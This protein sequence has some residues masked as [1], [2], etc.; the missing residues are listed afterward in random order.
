MSDHTNPCRDDGISLVEILVGVA[1][2]GLLMSSLSFAI[3]T[4]VRQN[5]NTTGRLNNARSEES[6]GVWMPAD[7]ASAQTVSLLPAHLLASRTVRSAWT[8]AVRTH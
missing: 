7:L 1:I 5:T 8:S 6:V 3:I 4:I 2:F